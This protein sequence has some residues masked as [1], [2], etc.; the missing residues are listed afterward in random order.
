MSALL[1]A[2]K[3]GQASLA[4]QAGQTRFDALKQNLRDH[5]GWVL[6]LF[7]VGLGVKFWLIQSSGSPFPYW[8]EW[9][10]E[11]I[12]VFI[13][14]VQHQF[15]FMKLFQAHNEHRIVFTKVCELGLFLANG[16]WDSRLEMVF[17]AFIHSG[18]IAGFGWLLASLLGKKSWPFVWVLLALTLVTPYAWENTIWGF[19][20]QFYF[21]VIFSILTIWLLGSS[22]PLSPRWRLGAYAA[23]ATLFTMASGFLAAVAVVGIT[24]VE[25]FKQ[26]QNWRRHLPT[27]GFCVAISILG[28]LLKKD[29]AFHH[30]F[31]AHSAGK[32]LAA[33]GKSLSW[34]WATVAWYAVFNLVPFAV[35]AWIYIRSK[36][37][38]KPAEQLILGIGFWVGLQSLAAAYARGSMGSPPAWR[39]M[40]LLSFIMVVNCVSI[41]LLATRYRE[42][43]RFQTFWGVV[44]ALWLVGCLTGLWYL[45]DKA[46]NTF[47]PE[48]VYEKQSQLKVARAFL[49]TDDLNALQHESA[50]R[51]IVP[52]LDAVVWLLRHPVVRSILPACAREALPVVPKEEGANA[53]IRSGWAL[54]EPDPATEVSWGC[55]SAKGRGASGTF[56]SLPVRKS[57]LPYLEI[58]VAG[59]LGQ[60]G[61]SLELVEIA[62]GKSTPVRPEHIAGQQWLNAYVAAPAGEFKIVAN[63]M[64]ETKWFAFK[65]PRE[66]GRL[67]FWAMRLL[68]GWRY[69]LLAGVCGVLIELGLVW[70]RRPALVIPA[71]SHTE[72]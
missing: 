48:V 12:D 5:F 44:F 14:W 20:S 31:Q 18:A 11:A 55:Y 29:V 23:I 70:T 33:L 21:M 25:V 36:G 35:L 63:N 46:L 59:D 50:E 68:T 71:S 66:M 54:T 52:N 53:F 60:A 39:Y 6:S 27:W 15:S 38:S 1:E 62:T 64:D 17:N 9:E 72:G 42:Q 47:I 57:S 37:G 30:Q 2:T 67:S 43:L 34:P 7:L 61:L 65:A 19:Q 45:T 16:Q 13:P 58:P 22:E 8:D 51:R 24:L 41:L 49:A 4:R 26:R 10:G 40:D 69:F 28:L 56:E 32:F 3:D